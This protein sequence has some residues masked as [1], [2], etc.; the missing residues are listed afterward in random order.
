MGVVQIS[1]SATA[2]K[3]DGIIYDIR[4]YNRIL[5]A[6]EVSTIYNMRGKDN[7]INGLVF[8]PMLK[9]AAGLSTFDGAVLAAGNTIY[10]PYSNT[11]GVPNGSPIAVADNKLGW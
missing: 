3:F 4:I 5:S 6:A 2:S 9:G 1:S 7:I 10:D 8:R 11:Y